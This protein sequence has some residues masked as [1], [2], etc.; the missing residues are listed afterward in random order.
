MPLTGI[1]GIQVKF[2]V[3]LLNVT[4]PVGVAALYFERVRAAVKRCSC[5]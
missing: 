3:Q 5:R 2:S 1:H 4:I